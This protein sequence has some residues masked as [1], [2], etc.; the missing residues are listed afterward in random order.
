MKNFHRPPIIGA[1]SEPFHS[2]VNLLV[3]DDSENVK[4]L[5][6]KA[7]TDVAMFMNELRKNSLYN[8]SSFQGKKFC[9]DS[10]PLPQDGALLIGLT[11]LLLARR[12][13]VTVAME[14]FNNKMYEYY[15]DGIMN[16]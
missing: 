13:G 8:K 15:E 9:F 1:F 10:Y 11:I 2:S 12:Y 6:A 3:T 16:A 14:T 4:D 5:I 7:V